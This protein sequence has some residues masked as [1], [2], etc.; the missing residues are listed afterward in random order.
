[1]SSAANTFVITSGSLSNTNINSVVDQPLLTTSSPTFNLPTFTGT[2]YGWLG[3]STINATNT[4]ITVSN[5]FV[6]IA[7]TWSLGSFVRN[8]DSPSNGILRYQGS[9]T[10]LFRVSHSVSGT[11][12]STDNYSAALYIN[13]VQVGQTVGQDHSAADSGCISREYILQLVPGDNL[14][15]RVS[16]NTDTSNIVCTWYS[17]CVTEIL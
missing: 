17:M 15:M 10:R 2:S 12:S 16:N 1:M 13:A 7:G 3:N 11:S 9:G 5:V 4:T 6:Q 14:T 8:F